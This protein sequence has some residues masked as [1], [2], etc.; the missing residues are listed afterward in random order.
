M[1]DP[2]QH[3]GPPAH[4]LPIDQQ[5]SNDS[6]NDHGVSHRVRF[7]EEAPEPGSRIHQPSPRPERAPAAT[8]ST[9]ATAVYWDD[10]DNDVDLDQYTFYREGTPTPPELESKQNETGRAGLDPPVASG[11]TRAGAVAAAGDHEHN[12]GPLSLGGAGVSD[13]NGGAG[14]SPATKKKLIRAVIIV[15]VLIIIGIA[16][17][18]GAGLGVGL[19]N[20]PTNQQAEGPSSSSSPN[21]ILDLGPAG[22][23]TTSKPSA[24]DVSSESTT[25]VAAGPRPSYN[26]DC[27]ALN[28]TIYRVP[29]STKSFLRICGIDYSGSNA[30]DLAHVY[31][32]SMADCMNSCASFDQC[33]GCSWGYLRGDSGDEHRCYMKKNLKTPHEAVDDWCF[34]VLQ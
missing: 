11:S 9:A 18:V 23:T 26:S 29:G 8:A 30:T 13:R 12:R 33:T 25:S 2:S 21:P 32:K 7:A 1:M 15:G 24:V 20:R 34:A 16:V 31:T 14:M 6:S 27:P 3:R 4:T 10:R 19:A 5:R 17:G 22:T 28:N